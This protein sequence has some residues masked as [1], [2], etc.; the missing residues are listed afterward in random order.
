MYPFRM[1]GRKIE[2]YRYKVDYTDTE[3]TL[4]F[5]EGAESIPSPATEYFVN[6]EEAHSFATANQG[7]LTE[8]DTTD[9]QWLDGIVVA[10]MP[11]TFAAALKIYELGQDGY[12]R[13]LA[14]ETSK[15][16]QQ[17]RADLDYVMLMG[18]L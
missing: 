4:D 9:Y 16:N 17:L 13:M 5:T 8:L 7:T 14:F 18:G 10:D 11:N 12:E 3:E 6:Q 15:K 1:Y 2:I